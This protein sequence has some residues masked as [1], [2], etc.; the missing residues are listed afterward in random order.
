MDDLIIADEEVRKL[1]DKVGKITMTDYSD[2]SLS[3]L[4]CALEDMV[5]DHNDLEDKIEEIKQDIENN[6]KPISRTEEI[7]YDE[8]DFY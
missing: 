1:L 3:S 4:V 5:L 7:G 6:Y 2:Y 8:R